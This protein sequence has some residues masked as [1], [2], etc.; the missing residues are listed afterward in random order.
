MANDDFDRQEVDRLVRGLSAPEPPAVPQPAVSQA[1][2]EP[3]AQPPAQPPP[4]PQVH[5]VSRWT[6]ARILMPAMR[7]AGPRKTFASAIGLPD[8]PA[9]RL[10]NLPALRLPDLPALRLPALTEATRRVLIIR[11]WVTLGL[12]LSVSLPYWPYPKTYLLGMLLYLFAVALLVVAGVWSAK[13][14]WDVRLGGAHTVSIGIVL[15]A[16]ALVAAETMPQVSG[17]S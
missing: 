8:L 6:S 7:T 2:A 11:A 14:T 17:G 3:P 13:L 16:I 12:L 5:R 1:S 9:L 10:P 4:A 15:W